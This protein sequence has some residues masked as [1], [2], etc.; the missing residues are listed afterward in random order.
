LNSAAAS[1][2]VPRPTF[3][4]AAGNLQTYHLSPYHER[5]ERFQM[6]H[7]EAC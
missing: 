4:N 7:V 6:P 1:T 5:R 3:T 2:L